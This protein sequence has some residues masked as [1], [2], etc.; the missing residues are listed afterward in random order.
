MR[1]LL[2]GL[3]CGIS[4]GVSCAGGNPSVSCPVTP[5]IVATPPDDPNA[6]PFGS[7]PW[8][9]NADRTVWAGW[10]AVRM[11]EGRNKV[12]WIRPPGTE[13]VVAGH[14]LDADAP[15]LVADVPC[16]YPTTF[17][18]SALIFPSGGCWK[19][20][21]AAGANKLTFVTSVRPRLP[22]EGAPRK[23]P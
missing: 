1:P 6:D 22:N 10:D 13:L 9:I 19:V 2:L 7:G 18:A 12:L 21:A 16:C 15:P 20:E 23:R 4:S 5:T 8:F 14:R 3:L 17:Q 11:Q